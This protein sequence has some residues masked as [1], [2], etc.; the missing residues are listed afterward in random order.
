MG[1]FGNMFGKKA[2]SICGETIAPLDDRKLEDGNLCKECASRLSPFFGERR[3]STVAEI[4]DQL[5]WRDENKKRV[6]QF[7]V[8]RTFG[9]NTKVLLDEHAQRFLVTTG[10]R[11]REANPTYSTSRR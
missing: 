7:N 6:A 10:G 9:N 2:C 5:A 8:T 3:R 11:W 1:L 4:S